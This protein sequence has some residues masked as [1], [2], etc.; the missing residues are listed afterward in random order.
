[1]DKIFIDTNV[2]LDHAL[3]REDGQPEEANEILELAEFYSIEACISQGSLYTLT[4]VL[5]KALGKAKSDKALSG[6]LSFLKL[7]SLTNKGA[8]LALQSG[9]KDTEDAFQYFTALEN[10]CQFFVTRNEKDFEKIKT[11]KLWV[12]SPDDYL[13][14]FYDFRIT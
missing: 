13:R 5:R 9:A 14:G 2:L 12:L 8:N 7:I 10:N 1:M 3:N 4:Y 6:Y 11:E